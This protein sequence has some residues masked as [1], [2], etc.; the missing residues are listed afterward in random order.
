M[1]IPEG[2]GRTRPLLVL[3]ACER[4]LDLK[5]LA[6][7]LGQ[8]RVRM[9]GRR[10]AEELTG[11][12]VGGISALAVRPG[13]FQVLLDAPAQH[14]DRIHVSA[15]VRGADLE[16]AVAD[17]VA[18]TGARFVEASSVGGGSEGPPD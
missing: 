10:E 16:L 9:A 15:G 13:T 3:I 17:L 8:K 4:Q 6:R 5:A 1:A 12:E 2:P 11:L 7:S 18:L 14:L